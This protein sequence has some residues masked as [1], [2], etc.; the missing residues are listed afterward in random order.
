MTLDE[1]T[2]VILVGGMTRMPMVRDLVKKF[3]KKEP[4]I[5]VNPDEAVA[6]GA[7]LQGEIISNSGLVATGSSGEQKELV[8]LDVTPLNLGIELHDGSMAVIIE[9]QSSIPCTKTHSFTTVQSFQ[10]ELSTKV[11]QGNRPIAKDNRLL[12]EYIINGIPPAP[13]GIPKIDVTFTVSANGTI[14]SSSKDRASGITKALTINMSGGLSEGDI[15]RMRK[16]A[17]KFKEQDESHQ[18]LVQKQEEARR[19]ISKFNESIS[20]N[21]SIIGN[22]DKTKVKEQIVLVQAAIDKNANFDELDKVVKQME[23]SVGKIFSD[24]YS[25]R[26]NK[27]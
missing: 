12:G 14:T 21:D 22:D 4:F 8:L 7:A 2:D 15:D 9:A 11:Y 19:A 25:S 17:E 16:E 3:F 13:A 10:T 24:A 5:G 6:V 20:S 1:I 27:Q 23:T 26:A 18:K